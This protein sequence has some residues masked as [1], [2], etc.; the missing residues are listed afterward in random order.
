MIGGQSKSYSVFSNTSKNNTNVKKMCNV[1]ITLNWYD[2]IVFPRN[3]R[4]KT[5]IRKYVINVL[6]DIVSGR[7]YFIQDDII[8]FNIHPLHWHA[9][10]LIY[11]TK[12]RTKNGTGTVPVM[13]N[14]SSIDYTNLWKLVINILITW[15]KKTAQKMALRIFL[16]SLIRLY[17]YKQLC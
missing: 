2:N 10:I 8:M 7:N 3:E 15:R 17:Q 12:F 14:F 11:F 13:H 5:K 4:N 9:F 16:W 1:S 6:I